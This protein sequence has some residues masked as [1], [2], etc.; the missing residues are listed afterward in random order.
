M[1]QNSVRPGFKFRPKSNLYEG[2]RGGFSQLLQSQPSL[3]TLKED[4]SSRCVMLPFRTAN[5][6]PVSTAPHLVTSAK[7]SQIRQV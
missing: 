7:L 1:W 2:F 3:E 5:R 4:E 6:I